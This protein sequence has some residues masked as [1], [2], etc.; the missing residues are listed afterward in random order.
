VDRIAFPSG[1]TVD[2]NGVLGVHSV[3]LTASGETGSAYLS[4][5]AVHFYRFTPVLNGTYTVTLTTEGS[6]TYLYTAA[7]WADGSGTLMTD[8]SPTNYNGIKT[9]SPF[10]AVK[11][12]VDLIIMVYDSTGN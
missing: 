7:A 1:W 12:G 10:I 11:P 2:G 5:G 3:A 6:Y 9:S 4:P 8:Y